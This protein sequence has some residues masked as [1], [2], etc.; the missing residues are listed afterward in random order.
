MTNQ[1][2]RYTA[3]QLAGAKY[4]YFRVFGS[5]RFAR[6]NT[7]QNAYIAEHWPHFIDQAKQALVLTLMSETT[8][9]HQKDVIEEELIDHFNRSQTANA[10]QVLQVTNDPREK[11]DVRYVDNNPQLVKVGI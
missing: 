6:E 8:P 2:I 11:E 3:K 4:D 7:D 9:Q 5:E 10:Y 1:L